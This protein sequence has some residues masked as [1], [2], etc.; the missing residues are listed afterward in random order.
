MP[1]DGIDLSEN[2]T[3]VLAHGTVVVEQG[4]SRQDERHHLSDEST[5]E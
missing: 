5:K 4:E 3:E 2:V 1:Y